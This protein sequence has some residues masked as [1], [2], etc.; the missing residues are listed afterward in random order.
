MSPLFRDRPVKLKAFGQD[1]FGLLCVE[2]FDTVIPS[3]W[4]RFK[5]L[6]RRSRFKHVSSIGR[7]SSGR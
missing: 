6:F 7:A 4:T 2:E 3:L 1:Q 5:R